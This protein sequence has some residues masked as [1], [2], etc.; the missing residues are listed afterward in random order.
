MSDR[1][2]WTA[3]IN[4]LRTL[5]EQLREYL[6]PFEAGSASVGRGG[7]DYTA[8]EIATVRR[9]I[10]SLQKTIDRVIAEKGLA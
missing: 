4:G 2:T 1:V 9:E 6:A 3:F 7:R 5:Q 10:A 8:D